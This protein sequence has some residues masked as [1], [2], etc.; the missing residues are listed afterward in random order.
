MSAICDVLTSEV[1]PVHGC[2]EMKDLR[3]ARISVDATGE[4]VSSIARRIGEMGER[5]GLGDYLE[6]LVEELLE[7]WQGIQMDEDKLKRRGRNLLDH[8]NEVED[9]EEE[10]RDGLLYEPDEEVRDDARKLGRA[11]GRHSAAIRRLKDE[12]KKAL[13]R[14]MSG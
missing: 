1:I 5:Y 2:A 13:S 12:E 9:L 7:D 14:A 10:E 3:R 6:E 11:M 8:V 4:E